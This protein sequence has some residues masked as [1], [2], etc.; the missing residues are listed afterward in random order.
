MG[1]FVGGWAVDPG[2]GGIHYC[3]HFTSVYA[4]SVYT[5]TFVH[6]TSVYT[7]LLSTLLLSTPYFCLR[8]TPVYT[9]LLSTPLFLRRVATGFSASNTNFNP[10]V[11]QCEA[12]HFCEN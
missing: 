6:A 7:L 12:K 2:L 1:L 9:I 8:F 3:L 5:F 4:T 11:R 10:S